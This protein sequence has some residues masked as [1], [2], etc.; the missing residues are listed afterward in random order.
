MDYTLRPATDADFN[1]LYNLN[2]AT[3]KDVVDQVWGWNEAFQQAYFK[4][5][6]NTAGASIIVVRGKDV[7]GLQYEEAPQSITLVE[8]QVLPEYQGKG[9]GTAILKHLINE[10]K[11]SRKDILLQVLK[12]NIRARRL[13]ERNGFTSYAETETHYQ[14]RIRN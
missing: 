8:L 9:L 10:A 12:P 1:F 5:H 4:E 13:Y 11:A 3:M 2:K 7:G 14:M 6:F